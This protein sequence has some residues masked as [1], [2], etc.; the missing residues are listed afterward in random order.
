MQLSISLF[1]FFFFFETEFLFVALA[2]FE[3]VSVSQMLEL[4]A[5]VTSA[6]TN[7][8]FIS[9]K[10]HKNLMGLEPSLVDRYKNINFLTLI[11]LSLLILCNFSV[12]MFN[13]IIETCAKSGVYMDT[14]KVL[15]S[16][17]I[18]MWI[19]LFFFTCQSC[20]TFIKF[21]DLFLQILLLVC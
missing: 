2:V 8:C 20:L 14:S 4:K 11:N 10:F 1:L 16:M 21:I 6:W 19:S 5:C 12:S 17:V 15:S 3:L 9:E 7:I 18:A 13:K